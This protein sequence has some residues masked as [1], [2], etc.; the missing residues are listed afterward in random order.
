GHHHQ[1]QVDGPELDRRGCDRYAGDRLDAVGHGRLPASVGRETVGRRAQHLVERV[2]LADAV[3]GNPRRHQL[4]LHAVVVA[5]RGGGRR[6]EED[7]D[8]V[9]AAAL[10]HLQGGRP[11]GAGVGRYG[12]QRVVAVQPDTIRGDEVGKGQVAGCFDDGQRFEELV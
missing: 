6:V 9:D 8:A 2:V 10:E 7:G 5:A 4:A 11:F 3:G 1:R 12:Q